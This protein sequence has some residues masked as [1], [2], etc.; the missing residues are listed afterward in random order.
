MIVLKSK[1]A[2]PQFDD[3]DDL[4][5]VFDFSVPEDE[6]KIRLPREL[7]VEARERAKHDGITL[8]ELTRRALK[9]DN[10]SDT[11]DTVRPGRRPKNT[12]GREQ[13]GDEWKIK[14][15]YAV[16]HKARAKAKQDGISLSSLAR[17][18]ITGYLRTRNQD[19]HPLF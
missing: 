14:L 15:P 11:A 1:D 7:G 8:T 17:R 19:E 6:W 4:A 13:L 5:H 9:S 3:V 16:G 18:A 12:D 2:Q 10:L